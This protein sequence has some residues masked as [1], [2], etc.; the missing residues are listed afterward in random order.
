ML[1]RLLYGEVP[2]PPPTRLSVTEAIA[3]ARAAAADHWLR[4]RLTV[5]TPQRNSSGAV[6][7][8]VESGGVGAHL[9]IVIDDASGA[10]LERVSS[11]GR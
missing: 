10:V 8:R 2:A 5:A 7:W 6:V 4:E 3:L 11:E 1:R 9:S